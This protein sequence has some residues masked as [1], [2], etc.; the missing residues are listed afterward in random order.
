MYMRNNFIFY[1]IQK[2][3]LF[4]LD[5]SRDTRQPGKPGKTALEQRRV[6]KANPANPAR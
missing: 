3:K 2:T 1:E 4:S 5:H 6:Q